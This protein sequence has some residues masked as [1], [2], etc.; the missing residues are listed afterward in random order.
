MATHILVG[1]LCTLY[2]MSHTHTHTHRYYYALVRDPRGELVET[3]TQ[4]LSILLDYTP[5]AT[6]GRSYQAT[7]TQPG[8]PGV[9]APSLQEPGMGN[10][11][12]SFISRLHQ[13]E[14]GGVRE[15]VMV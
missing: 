11:F 10:L 1:P 9:Q 6:Q 2:T 8:R 14:V 5:P 3:S 4:I 13:N 12:C 7:P 15:V